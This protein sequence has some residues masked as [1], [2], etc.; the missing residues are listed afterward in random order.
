[1]LETM[2]CETLLMTPEGGRNPLFVPGE[3]V[4]TFPADASMEERARRIA[5]ALDRREE[6]LR[7]RR[8]GRQVMERCCNEA[9]VL[10]AHLRFVLAAFAR[11]R[12]A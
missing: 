1:M 5:D 8:R 4:E 11:T 2:S 7:I 10:D 9:S 6:S 3:T 12:Q